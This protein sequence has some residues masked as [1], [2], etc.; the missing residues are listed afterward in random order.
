MQRRYVR[1]YTVLKG[2]SFLSKMPRYMITKQLW[3][4]IKEKDLQNPSNKRQVRMCDKK[5]SSLIGVQIVCDE[6]LTSLFGKG[7]VE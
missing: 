4:Y 1:V 5:D 6:T 7:T 3:A 2:R